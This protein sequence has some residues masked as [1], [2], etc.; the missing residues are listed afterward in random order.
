MKPS[1]T[2]LHNIPLPWSTELTNGV[3]NACKD[4]SISNPVKI[5]VVDILFVRQNAHGMDP[6]YSELAI[7]MDL[8][9][10]FLVGFMNYSS[11]IIDVKM[12]NFVF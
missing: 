11:E 9:V 3:L 8:F 2:L 12:Y 4:E 6:V 7:S 1:L 10:Q 5:Q